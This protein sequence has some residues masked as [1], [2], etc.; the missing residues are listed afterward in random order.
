MLDVIIWSPDPAL[1]EHINNIMADAG[2]SVLE[3][4][5]IPTTTIKDFKIGNV[6]PAY[7]SARIVA[8]EETAL[9]SYKLRI[10]F[11]EESGMGIKRML[12]VA[13]HAKT[14][15]ISTEQNVYVSSVKDPDGD[16][17]IKISGFS[18]HMSMEKTFKTAA[19]T[20]K[21]QSQHNNLCQIPA[22]NIRQ[23]AGKAIAG[24]SGPINMRYVDVFIDPDMNTGF[25]A[26]A[27]TGKMKPPSEESEFGPPATIEDDS[28]AS[29]ESV[30]DGDDRAEYI[31]VAFFP[32]KFN[33]TEN[34]LPKLKTFIEIISPMNKGLKARIKMLSRMS[35]VTNLRCLT[36]EDAAGERSLSMKLWANDRDGNRLESDI[37]TVLAP[38]EIYDKYTEGRDLVLDSALMNAAISTTKG[39]LQIGISDKM[40][41]FVS[42]DTIACTSLKLQAKK[43]GNNS[44][45]QGVAVAPVGDHPVEAALEEDMS[46]VTEGLDSDSVLQEMQED[47]IA[48]EAADII[49]IEDTANLEVVPKRLYS[50]KDSPIGLGDVSQDQGVNIITIDQAEAS[51]D[52]YV[53]YMPLDGMYVKISN[54]I[55][56]DNQI[57]APVK[58]KRGSIKH[59]VMEIFQNYPDQ[60]F[61]IDGLIAASQDALEQGRSSTVAATVSGLVKENIVDRAGRAKYKLSPL[62]RYVLV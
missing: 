6:L 15:P 16:V 13:E 30:I 51:G 20:D 38:T 12:A 34:P 18:Q 37:A 55:V 21:T 33:M 42:E 29:D 10:A 8:K 54:R 46:I 19:F 50:I 3:G 35:D 48:S 5:T 60:I 49:P 53:C 52:Y 23:F 57:S 47:A 31:I 25:S 40:V 32:S 1:A 45:A 11:S 36:T 22:A 14:N 27:I 41:C 17:S 2:A 44:E 62:A 7:M 59:R 9:P 24:L 43:Q 56:R 58:V 28:I 26:M 39:D 4:I 61:T